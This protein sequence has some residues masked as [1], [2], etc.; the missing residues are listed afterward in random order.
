MICKQCGSDAISVKWS[1]C[2]KGKEVIGQGDSAM[3]VDTFISRST[4]YRC[5]DCNFVFL[6]YSKKYGND[7]EKL[8]EGSTCNI[9]R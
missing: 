8:D 1:W 5:N 6:K 7:K 4:R 2:R 9:I 3:E